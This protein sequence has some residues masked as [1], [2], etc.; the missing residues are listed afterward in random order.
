MS[1][2]LVQIR[3]ARVE[4]AAEISQLMTVLAGYFVSDPDDTRSAPFLATLTQDSI[5]V[6]LMHPQ[7]CYYVAEVDHVVQGVLC[8]REQQH[9]H[10]LFVA[11]ASQRQGLARL[12]WIHAKTQARRQGYNGVFTVNS[13]L[14]AVPVC[15]RLGF[16][17]AAAPVARNGLCYVPMCTVATAPG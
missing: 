11:A 10:H 7:F 3:L 13:S 14:Y 5:E 17:V 16:V 2:S 8:L 9:V 12:L 15:E 1:K 4:Q 6:L